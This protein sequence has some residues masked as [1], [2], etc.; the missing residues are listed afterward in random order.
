M[1]IYLFGGYD[2]WMLFVNGYSIPTCPPIDPKEKTKYECNVEAKK[3]I[4]GGITDIVSLKVKKCK[5][6]K[7]VWD[8]LKETYG[9]VLSTAESDYEKKEKRRSHL[10]M[11][12]RRRL[13]CGC[14]EDEKETQ[15]RIAQ[16]A[17][18]VEKTYHCDSASQSSRLDPFGSN[19]ENE[20]EDNNVEVDLEGELVSAL[21]EL[22]NVRKEFKNYKK[23]VQEECD[24]LRK[25]LEESNKNINTLT[26][27]LEEAKGMCEG[28]KSDFYIKKRR[29]VELELEV[30]TKGKECQ[31]LEDE[32]VN[33]KK[34]LE[35]CQEDLK[36]RMKYEGSISALNK[37]LNQQKKNK[38]STGL[39][40][41][42]GQCSTSGE[43][44]KGEI[45][46]V[47]SSQDGNGNTFTVVATKKNNVD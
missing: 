21:E 39:G 37:M 17:L 25:C 16:E 40:C 31:K 36:L 32:V 34:E 7:D 43:T 47:S 28:I 30:G 44:Y 26:A 20:E 10:S 13:D 9:E 42:V 29:C 5:P 8:K 41:E 22:K 24:Q 33:L 14:S 23:S 18:N 1:E 12:D 11:D 6:A 2:V 46:F 19:E 4:L 45:N 3:T 38:D 15:F 35:K 27:Q